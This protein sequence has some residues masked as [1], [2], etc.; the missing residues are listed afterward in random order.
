PGLRHGAERGE[1]DVEVEPRRDRVSG[2]PGRPRTLGLGPRFESVD[3]SGAGPRDGERSSH[4]SEMRHGWFVIP[5]VQT[6]D[7]TIEDQILAL[8]PAL[9]E[10][11]EKSVLDLGC[12]EGLISLEFA[13]AGASR[14]LSIDLV[15]E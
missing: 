10:A 2:L 14:V 9:A 3:V 4:R 7:R 12:A 13:R 6:G 15:R 11:K 8:R 5:G 1:A